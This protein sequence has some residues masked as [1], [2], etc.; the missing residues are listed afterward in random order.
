MKIQLEITSKTNKNIEGNERK[1]I[2]NE[3]GLTE[4]MKKRTEEV[5]VGIY[6]TVLPMTIK[7]IILNYSIGEV[8]KIHR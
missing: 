6:S 7:N 4:Q 3:R 8:L 5:V 1:K 2:K